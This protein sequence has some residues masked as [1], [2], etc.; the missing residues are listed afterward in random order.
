MPKQ[1]EDA[2]HQCLACRY[3]IDAGMQMR[4]STG[5]PALLPGVELTSSIAAFSARHAIMEVLE[6]SHHC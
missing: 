3:I 2:S 4:R 6:V 5:D 1:T